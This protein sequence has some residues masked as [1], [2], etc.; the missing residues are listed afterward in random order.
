M[1][2]EIIGLEEITLGSSRLYLLE[3]N[4]LGANGY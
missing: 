2:E 3:S 1:Q 4:L